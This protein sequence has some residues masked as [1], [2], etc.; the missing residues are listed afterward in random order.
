MTDA[1]TTMNPGTVDLS[2]S[3]QPGTY[4][5]AYGAG[6]VEAKPDEPAK[7]ESLD[8]VIRDEM[9]KQDAEAKPE[10]AE[11]VDDE[12]PE[13]KVEKPK[14]EKK[15]DPETAPKDAV[16]DAVPEKDGKEAAGREKP[17]SE[18]GRVPEPPARLLPKAREVWG[19]VPRE[20]KAEFERFE[21][22]YE[23]ERETHRVAKQFHEELR[24]YD[25]MAKQANT[26]VKA[27][28]DRYV[29]F[30]K[31]LA[32]DFGR[33]MAA[34]A[35]DQR[36][37][38]QEAITSLMRAYGITP[39]QFAQA[40]VKNPA[41]FQGQPMPQQQQQPRVDP[42]AQ[43]A[44]A[45][46]QSLKQQI[47]SQQMES[48]VIAPFVAAHPRFAELQPDIEKLLKSGIVPDSLNPAERLATAYDMAERLKPS[49]HRAASAF[50]EPAPAAD[51]SPDAGRKS[52][53]GAPSDGL[54]PRAED[55]LSLDDFLRKEMRKIG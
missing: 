4:D 24:E 36:K 17:P 52:V 51:P 29:N 44:L 40:V 50:E 32:Q 46:V 12:K 2:T 45:E 19:N 55:N 25:G 22:E 35:Q 13:P 34:I 23:A 31:Q 21:R 33:G 43:K 7:P 20:V 28:L 18:G 3:L 53:R 48:T 10:K 9:K 42:I 30:D 49:P 14:A 26:S 41:Q 6:K 5:T 39:A 1:N 27:A 11:D 54:T 15:E 47:A 37:S 38:P 8:S 16:K